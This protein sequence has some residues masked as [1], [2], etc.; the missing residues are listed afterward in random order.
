MAGGHAVS[1]SI[2]CMFLAMIVLI[3]GVMPYVGKSTDPNAAYMSL[4]DTLYFHWLDDAC[5]AFAI[6]ASISFIRDEFDQKSGFSMPLL[7]ISE[8]FGWLQMAAI[9]TF[10]PT[11]CLDDNRLST[12]E[13]ASRPQIQTG[14]QTVT[15][16][17][18]P[19]ILVLTMCFG[20]LS[21]KS[22]EGTYKAA[23][24]ESE[25]EA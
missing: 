14:A 19:A 7:V 21:C 10:N 2:L 9:F 8:I 12:G 18:L 15:H 6:A 24:S 1:T 22:A 13:C 20:V 25:S 11:G 5:A 3:G 16:V 17:W 23:T 4:S